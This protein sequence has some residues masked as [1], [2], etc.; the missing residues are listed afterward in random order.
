MILFLAARRFN[1]SMDDLGCLFVSKYIAH[2]FNQG[3]EWQASQPSKRD[4]QASVR[5][6]LTSS[7]LVSEGNAI[8]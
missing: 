4:R 1:H 5:D 3:I 2:P 6:A 7:K 8:H